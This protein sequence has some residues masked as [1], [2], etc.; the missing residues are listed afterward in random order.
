MKNN[1]KV[2]NAP[3]QIIET[4]S[5]QPSRAEVATKY[6]L[7]D[8]PGAVIP[9]SRIAKI[10]QQLE[11]SEPISETVLESLQKK[12]FTALCRYAK[13]KST[14]S[15]YLKD[16]E[17]ERIER[18]SSAEAKAARAEAERERKAE[19]IQKQL[20]KKREQ[21]EARQRAYDNDPKNI[22][23]AQQYELRERYDL[24]FFIENP[25]FPKLMNILRQVDRGK[26]LSEKD[27]VWLSTEGHDYFTTE[28]KE[29][30]HRNEAEFYAAE[31][32]KNKDPWSAVNASSQYR[33][34]R[35][36][37]TADTMLNSINV[38]R[39]KNL[40]LK[41]ALY[42]TH[43]GVKRDLRKFNDA[44]ALAEQARILTPKN[45]RPYTLLGAVNME[46][47]QYDLGQSWYK[48]AIERGYSEKSM[49][50]ELRSIYLRSDKSKQAALRDHL[51]KIDPTRYSWVKK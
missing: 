4:P 45:F 11:M 24:T 46:I 23:K 31:F 35:K 48:K 44:L 16:A 5:T 37:N 26:R 29:G 2:H 1:I 33:K 34:C 13:M 42:T 51:L 7:E 38:P 32:K 41:S 21:A 9:G 19:A 22:A 25:D 14:F 43:G 18:C 27:V 15:E 50:S 30:F 6:R 17:L 36:A 10:L 12:G 28:L 8:L 47:G 20:R 49:D 39:L 3:H 40:K